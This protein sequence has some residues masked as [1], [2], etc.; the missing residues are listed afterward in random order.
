[1][2][3]YM[4]KYLSLNVK[5][6]LSGFLHLIYPKICL[7]CGSTDLFRYKILC[8]N[9]YDA[10]PFTQFFEIENNAIE[11]IFWGRI[12]LGASGAG[13]FFTKKSIVQILL[14]ELKYK[15]NKKAGWLLGSIIGEALLRTHQFGNIDFL[16]PL[17]LTKKKE[18][19]R[20][21]NQS[22]ILCEGIHQ[23]LPIPILTNVLYKNKR[24]ITQTHKD[25]IE[26]GQS[27]HLAFTLK[28][29]GLIMDKR[30]ILVDDVVTT[31]ATAEWALICLQQAHPAALHFAAAAY[32]LS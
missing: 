4:T 17:P 5:S 20:G 2:F 18:R 6:Y 7:Q 30:L 12:V 13:L 27:R 19:S 21:F 26:R 28:N 29:T 14:F 1:M 32:T 15:Q 10:L 23:V 3:P 16:I 31:G 9:C 22:F 24:G 25:R 11:K 8:P